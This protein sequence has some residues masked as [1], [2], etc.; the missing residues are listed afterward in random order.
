[1]NTTT[2]DHLVIA[3][4]SLAQGVQWCE[5][6][7]CITPGPGGSH[8]KMG[9]H[10]RLFSIAGPHSPGVYAEII[11]I[12]PAASAPQRRRWFGLD[13]PAVQA[14]LLVLLCQ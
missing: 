5:V 14:A 9:T 3:A 10:N 2:L 4:S 6:T 8:V 12:D 13:E 11:A 1:M 7:L